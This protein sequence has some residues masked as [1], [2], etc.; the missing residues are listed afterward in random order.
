MNARR[1]TCIRGSI[2]RQGLLRLRAA[3]LVQNRRVL[4]YF[5]DGGSGINWTDT[6]EVPSAVSIVS[7]NVRP[8]RSWGTT[9]VPG[10]APFLVFHD[11]ARP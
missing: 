10:G 5:S 1:H 6:G 11:A 9:R 7:W 2:H 3:G 4:F 8:L